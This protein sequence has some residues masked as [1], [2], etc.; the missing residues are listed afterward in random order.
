MWHRGVRAIIRIA[1]YSGLRVGEI[2]R[3]ERIDG[4]F[5]LR[6]TKNG[7]AHVIVP[8]ILLALLLRFDARRYL[9]GENKKGSDGG[10][11]AS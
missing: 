4:A 1:F 11:A 3:A 8:G 5:V 10:A 7:A 6:D 9:I 2:Q